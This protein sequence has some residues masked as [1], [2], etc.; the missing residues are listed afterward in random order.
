MIMR[1]SSDFR[2][3][4]RLKRLCASDI[5]ELCAHQKNVLESDFEKR[6][7]G[8]VIACL[9][10]NR[11]DIRSSDCRSSV[12]HVMGLLSD[13]FDYDATLKVC[14]ADDE[15]F[16]ADVESGEE[17][18][19]TCLR[20]K[21]EMLSKK[22]EAALFRHDTRVSGDI[23][24]HSSIQ[25]SCHSEIENHCAK[26]V[27]SHIEGAVLECLE[28]N[29]L[30]KTY[31][32]DCIEAM[33]EYEH[34]STRDF[35]KD[36]NVDKT[37]ES[38][39]E[40]ECDFDCTEEDVECGGQTI[41]CLKRKI[42]EISSL[43]CKESVLRLG[44]IGNMDFENDRIFSS[45]CKS[46]I[47][48]FCG[49]QKAFQQDNLG[50]VYSCI[51]NHFED[52]TEECAAAT[53]ENFEMRDKSILLRPRLRKNCQVEVHDFCKDEP[54]ELGCL[55][56]AGMKQQFS[57]AC[58]DSLT[59]FVRIAQRIEGSVEQDDIEMQCSDDFHDFCIAD[60]TLSDKISCIVRTLNRGGKHGISAGCKKVLMESL[61]VSLRFYDL[62]NMLTLDCD[63][64][65]Q[66]HCNKYA[67]KGIDM[68]KCAMRL[69]RPY[70]MDNCKQ[71]IDFT[72]SS[73]DAHLTGL[74]GDYRT[75]E[76]ESTKGGVIITGWIAMLSISALVVVLVGIGYY[77]YMRYSGAAKY[78]PYTIVTKSGDV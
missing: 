38:F 41:N 61:S 57:P 8:I 26:E 45:A 39:I 43:E 75:S 2:L 14:K 35:R 69:K 7:E 28:M 72:R 6:E 64:D 40:Q 67:G 58:E 34:Q 54:D 44:M 53:T 62:G 12:F 19:L 74:T 24:F 30:T 42:D 16:C 17:K 1:R 9:Q 46:D 15:K 48:K 32:S 20:A 23:H 52:L 73:N 60:K 78:R 5:K 70:E 59:E 50:D 77:A 22:C 21:E 51:Q 55:T 71:I 68:Y 13:N 47:D 18:K 31:R 49:E 37:C 33:R 4:R 65:L 29:M 11:D 76:P 66:K 56:R 63:N 25:K 3:D 10:D 27:L 36:I